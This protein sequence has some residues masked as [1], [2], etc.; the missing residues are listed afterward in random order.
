MKNIAREK[1]KPK[2]F[3]STKSN[4]NGPKD[5]GAAAQYKSHRLDPMLPCVS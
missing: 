4:D 1:Q 3:T 5:N 2:A